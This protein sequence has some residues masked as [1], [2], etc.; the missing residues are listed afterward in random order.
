[1]ADLGIQLYLKGGTPSAT[2]YVN[3]KG[4]TVT[5]DDTA[6]LLG[7]SYLPGTTFQASAGQQ[8]VLEVIMR[9]VTATSITLKL[10]TQPYDPQGNAIVADTLRGI[11][12]LDAQ[13]NAGAWTGATVTTPSAPIAGD[14]ELVFTPLAAA[15]PGL[16]VA[17]TTSAR[18][19]GN[20]IL[21]AKANA[22]ALN[23]NDYIIVRVK[24]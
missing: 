5:L 20:L 18:L 1:M 24:S 16:I 13:D 11:L 21:S 10:E 3:A 23:T 6:N 7:A 19:T 15:G 14:S 17:M 9:F 2:S 22:G 8:V 4:N 12:L